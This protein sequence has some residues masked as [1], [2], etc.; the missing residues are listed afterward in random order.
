MGEAIVGGNAAERPLVG[1]GV[2]LVRD[3]RVLLARR[4][5]SHGDGSYSW[6]GGH[7]ELGESFE[8][9]AIREVREESGLIVGL[10]PVPQQ[11]PRLRHALRGHPAPRGGV[12]RRAR[13]AQ[14]RTRSPAGAGAPSTRCPARCSGRWK[15]AIAS[16]RSGRRTLSTDPVRRARWTAPHRRRER[17]LMDASCT[18]SRPKE[19]ARSFYV[20]Q[21]RPLGERTVEPST[22]LDPIA[23]RT[24]GTAHNASTRAQ[25][26]GP[27]PLELAEGPCG[28]LVPDTMR[29]TFMQRKLDDRRP[30]ALETAPAARGRSSRA[31]PAT[32]SGRQALP[33]HIAN[34]VNLLFPRA[35][36]SS[37]GAS[38]VMPTAWRT[39]RCAPR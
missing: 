7:L 27:L 31:S 17:A 34:A 5:G 22:W 32:G 18:G 8:D 3:G 30:V 25:Q 29:F 4:R 9:C 13:G 33:A 38:R 35:S 39:R 19:T 2:M 36:A 21:P 1:V 11:H 20:V 15:L 14:A 16:Y 23:Q 6:C 37:S 24:P 10:L 12:R 28:E 26:E